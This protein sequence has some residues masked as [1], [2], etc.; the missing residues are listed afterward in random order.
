MFPNFY[1]VIKEISKNQ[2]DF[3]MHVLPFILFLCKINKKTINITQLQEVQKKFFL[4]IIIEMF[5]YFRS[6]IGIWYPQNI[7][8]VVAQMSYCHITNFD[9]F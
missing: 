8:P 3:K 1:F 2:D 6:V 7:N 9:W 5:L 4:W